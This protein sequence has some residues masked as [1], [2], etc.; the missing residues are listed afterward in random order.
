MGDAVRKLAFAFA[1]IFL[2]I[3][4]ANFAVAAK[5]ALHLQCKMYPVEN[6]TKQDYFKLFRI[7]ADDPDI[8]HTF[9]FI[10]LKDGK[11]I[12]LLHEGG[13]GHLTLSVTNNK[14][15]I[16][17]AQDAVALDFRIDRTNGAA[18]ME[19][20]IGADHHSAVGSCD[21]T[22]SSPKDRKF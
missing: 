4:T 22:E 8:D 9:E 16:S 10:Q 1:Q 6:G 17:G 2:M 13:L 21:K 12:D 7:R 19:A 20:A 5:S 18:K 3:T 15:I 14:L 11:W